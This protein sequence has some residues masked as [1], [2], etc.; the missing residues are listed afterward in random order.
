VFSIV[1]LFQCKKERQRLGAKVLSPSEDI[2]KIGVIFAAAPDRP[3]LG[4]ASAPRWQGAAE[5]ALCG[6]ASPAQPI[7]SA[8]L[9]GDRD[10]ICPRY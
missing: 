7:Q 3:M 4:T 5:K 2:E 9:Q 10:A 6:P 1:E 8:D